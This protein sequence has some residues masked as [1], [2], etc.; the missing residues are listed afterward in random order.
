[1]RLGGSGPSCTCFTRRGDALFELGDDQ[2]AAGQI[3]ALVG[4]LDAGG[5]MPLFVFDGGY[6]SAQLTL[7]LPGACGGGGAG[8]AAL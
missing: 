3:R 2:T 1:M 4:R 6:D 5:R 7:D 8:A